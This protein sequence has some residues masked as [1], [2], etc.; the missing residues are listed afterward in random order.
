MVRMNKIKEFE[1]VQDTLLSEII[2]VEERLA[3]LKNR[4]TN[5]HEIGVGDE[6][7]RSIGKIYTLIGK[8]Q[9]L[10]KKI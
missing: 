3:L 1:I 4:V 8:Y 2:E 6:T 10:S 7:I 9:I 5:S